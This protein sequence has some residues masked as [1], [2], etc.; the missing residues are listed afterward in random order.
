[1]KSILIVIPLLFLSTF[2][3]GCGSEDELEPLPSQ[4]SWVTRHGLTSAN[5]QSEFDKWT[6]AGYR[7]TY[8]SGHQQQ[9]VDGGVEA[10]YNAIW[11]KIS[12]PD[13][14]AHHD[15]TAAQYQAAVDAAEREGFQPT[16]V[17]AFNVANTVLFAVV[18]EKAQS[19]WV[20]R[21]G[22][23]S[24]EYQTEADLR[25][26]EEGYRIRYVSGY[27][28]DGEARFAAIFD[29]SPSPDWAARHNMDSA[30]YQQ[31]FDDLA[32]QGLMPVVIDG[33]F[34]NGEEQ[35][36]A[37]WHK[38]DARYGARHQVKNGSGYQ[39]VA[40][41]FYY[42]GYRPVAIDGY[43]DGSKVLYATTWKNK[44]WHLSE[45]D[46]LNN[47]VET[48]R[49][50]NSIPSISLAIVKDEK[51]VYAKAFGLADQ[52]NDEPA[53]TTH[54]YRIASLSKALTGAAVTKLIETTTLG[55]TDQ[56]FGSNGLLS[57][58]GGDGVL[59]ESD[60]ANIQLQDMLEH[61]NGGWGNS[62][63]CSSNT[64]DEPIMFSNNTESRD[65]IITNTISNVPLPNTPANTFCYSNFAYAAL[66]AVIE[67][68]NGGT[69]YGDYVKQ[70]LAT[71]SKADSLEIGGNLLTDRLTN[72]VKYY[73]NFDPYFWNVERMAGHGGWVVTPIDY[74]RI[75]TKL[76][77][78][79]YRQDLLGATG[80]DI[81]TR[82]D[83]TVANDAWNISNGFYG[84]GLVR[85]DSLGRWN[86]NGNFTGSVAEYM[87][88]DD[89]FSIMMVINMRRV[90]GEANDLS[91]RSLATDI[92][93][94]DL[95]YP[96]HD[97]F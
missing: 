13:W 85:N 62:N 68:A 82:D 26:D 20:A 36:A 33:F 63:G 40:D 72:E 9:N 17:D 3:T 97:L 47:M 69:A 71:P 34:V 52:E 58:Y 25:V 2:L 4:P 89:G 93:A 39:K 50:S 95:F 10:R 78:S 54:R 8:V 22:M 18:F 46:K 43:G 96:S 48:F 90:P 45:L 67:A 86:H 14:Y 83:V 32:D 30:G 7:L 28:V 12:G 66:E 16:I 23:T 24:D 6:E 87:R 37:I 56:V 94:E 80:I 81:Y 31:E 15:L 27:E 76:D 53:T 92:Y 49:S 41:D 74:L 5:Y 51:L 29:Q 44:S 21:H 79:N 73:D 91:I 65:W 70:E 11:E 1:M 55:L 75:M 88:Y 59:A 60:I 42:E 64:A 77:G 84:K 38:A 35:F 57:S 61:T 19:N